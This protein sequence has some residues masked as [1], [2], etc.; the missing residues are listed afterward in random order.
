MKAE[1]GA[2]LNAGRGALCGLGAEVGVETAV[3]GV[4]D[5]DDALLERRLDTNAGSDPPAH[6]TVNASKSLS[7]FSEDAI[8]VNYIRRENV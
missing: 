6:E 7:P 5:G 2:T 3:D 4:D 8:V 1:L